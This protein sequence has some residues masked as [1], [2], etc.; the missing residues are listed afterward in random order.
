MLSTRRIS[1]ALCATCIAL[2]ALV[3]AALAGPATVT[4]RV[5][6]LNETKLPPT[7]VTTTSASVVKDGN[8]ED[9]CPGTSA[10]GALELATGGNWGG[11]WSSKFK[12]YEIFSIEGEEHVFEESSS[13]NYFWSF[14]LNE[15]EAEIGACGAELQPGDR[16]LFFP[17]CFGSTCPSGS[18][19]PLGIELPATATVGEAVPVTVKQ[20]SSSGAAAPATGASL[21]GGAKVETTDSGGH[22]TL[23]FPGAGD[24]TVRASAPG[25]VRTE[26]V[27]C[28]HAGNDGTCGTQRASG[29]GPGAPGGSGVAGFTSPSSG[30]QAIAAHVSG[31]I[32]GHVYVPAHSPRVLSGSVLAHAAVSSVSLELRRSYKGR[33]SAYDGRRERFVPQHCGRGSFFKVS[34]DGVFSYLLPFSLGPG[35]YVLDLKATDVA[36]QVTKLARGT[37]RFVF[38]VR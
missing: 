33:C 30:P 2:A 3:P 1:V 37:T 12:Q 35:R 20:Y 13:A 5:E 17:S 28:V 26:T 11:P 9:S 32:E 21:T 36:G 19:T 27:I 16:V 4:V 15:K 25:A 14:W 22:A 23:S 31:L 18:Q 29:S 10:A 34:S 24:V 7:Q 8:S 6:G 38:Y